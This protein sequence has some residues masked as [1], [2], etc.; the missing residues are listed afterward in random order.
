MARYIKQ[1]Q[2]SADA[3][4]VFSSVSNYLM[5]EG[6]EYIEY[7]GESVFKKGSGFFSGPSFFKFS[8]Q[9]TILQLE[10]WMKYS[11]LPG[12]YVGE[13]GLTGF[14]GGAVKGV[15]KKRV[16]VIEQMLS[17]YGIA[18]VM[19]NMQD[20]A[21]QVTAVNVQSKQQPSFSTNQHQNNYGFSPQQPQDTAIGKREFIDK[22]ASDLKHDYKNISIAGYIL[23]G[24]NL[25]ICLVLNPIGIIDALALLG[26]ILG[27]HLGKSKVCAILLLILSILES[28]IGMVLSG[29]P[30][31]IIW[32]II[33]IFAVIVSN[34]ASKRYKAF[35]A[36]ESW[37]NAT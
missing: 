29:V 11:L 27:F 16:A 22:Y 34:K 12:L 21:P 35:K 8:F 1:Y 25:I 19:N 3:N 20:N 5:S 7:N 23:A 36:N 31:G 18:V 24:I 14:V 28:V 13:L 15:W 10:T 33:G 26:F 2:L 32:I 9:G 17:N 4:T 37:P 6:Y 30:T